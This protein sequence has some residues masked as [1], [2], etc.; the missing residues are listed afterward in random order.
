M[1]KALRNLKS[2]GIK[3]KAGDLIDASEAKIIG[4]DILKDLLN[5][6]FILKVEEK[7]PELKEDLPVK[8]VAKKAKK[9]VVKKSV[10]IDL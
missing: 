2:N 1:Y 10:S 3:K 9:K 7:K 4:D 6:D 5:K 8:K